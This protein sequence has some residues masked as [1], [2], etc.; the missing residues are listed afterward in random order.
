M[1]SLVRKIIFLACLLLLIIAVGNLAK[2]YMVRSKD[3]QVY[4]TLI[5]L[6]EE[7]EEPASAYDALYQ[8]NNDLVGWI[9]I[10][11][12]TINYPVMQTI[13]DPE[14]YLHKDF[15]GSYSYTGTPFVSEI[16]QLDPNSDNVVIYGHNMTDDSMFAPL[17]NYKTLAFCEE[18]KLVNF[19]TL[20]ASGTYEVVYAFYEDVSLDN[21]HFEFYAFI[22]AKNQEDYD[23]FIATCS[24]KS[25]YN[26]GITPQY[27]EKL[28]T[29]V[30][31]S[32]HST[33]GRFVVICRQIES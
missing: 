6:V 8:E 4:E 22:N 14:Y 1:K 27:G 9:E 28:L 5:E 3:A 19:N 20:Q 15:Y 17:L 24:A 21:G 2:E 33:N 18:H 23:Q 7:F 11:G 32:Y 25:L 10:E 12:T 31:C 26:T 29:L 13:S 16:S 30:T